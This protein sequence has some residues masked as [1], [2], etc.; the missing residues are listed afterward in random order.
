MRKACAS[1]WKEI[2]NKIKSFHKIFSPFVFDVLE[3]KSCFLLRATK[4]RKTDHHCLIF[5]LSEN[6]FICLQ[7]SVSPATSYLLLQKSISPTISYFYPAQLG[8]EW[9]IYL[10]CK[11]SA[12]IL[13]KSISNVSVFASF[14]I[15]W[16]NWHKLFLFL[17]STW[18]H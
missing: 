3:N 18:P 8:K 7:K 2:Q 9:K 17:F 14:A 16:Q 6:L 4:N 15:N 1:I 10:G 13:V 11:I 5:F 12:K